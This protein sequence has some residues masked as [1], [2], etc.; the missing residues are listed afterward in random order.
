MT[1][2]QELRF[3]VRVRI[4]YICT[5]AEWISAYLACHSAFVSGRLELESE[6]SLGFARVQFVLVVRG[7]A[8]AKKQ[9]ETRLLQ[10]DTHNRKVRL[11]PGFRFLWPLF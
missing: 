10:E 6:T 5:L 7:E 4:E 1:G 11:N 3:P 8:C 9:E 2:P